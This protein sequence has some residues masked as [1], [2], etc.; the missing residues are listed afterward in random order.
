MTH[1]AAQLGFRLERGPSARISREDWTGHT[2]AC[3]NVEPCSAIVTPLIA[4]KMIYSP[5]N[6]RAVGFES[7]GDLVDT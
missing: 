3:P 7:S 6:E 2:L 1:R 5:G 4:V